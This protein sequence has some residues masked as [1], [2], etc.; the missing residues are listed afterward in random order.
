MKLIATEIQ[1]D[2]EMIELSDEDKDLQRIRKL[3]KRTTAQTICIFMLAG[4]CFWLSIRKPTNISAERESG[5]VLSIDEKN[6]VNVG[7]FDKIKTKRLWTKY[8][9]IED[10]A[11]NRRAILGTHNNSVQFTLLEKDSQKPRYILTLDGNIIEEKFNDRIGHTRIMTIVNG[12]DSIIRL[13]DSNGNVRMGLVHANADDSSGL[14]ILDKHGA[15]VNSI[16]GK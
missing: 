11:G 16:G 9:V 2:P 4:L 15:V 8:L 12:R 1:N 3:E 6:M 10:D 14:V 5:K 13:H 7:Q